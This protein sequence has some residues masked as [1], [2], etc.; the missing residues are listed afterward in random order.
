VSYAALVMG[1]GLAGS[2]AALELARAGRSVVLV[3]K[4]KGPH[5]KVCGEFLSRE[6]LHY[7]RRHN[8][9]LL[10]LGAVPIKAVR[11]IT[12][13]FAEQADLPFAAMSL[14]RRRLD[15]ELLRLAIAA[16]VEVHRGAFVDGLDQEDGTWSAHLRDGRV[17]QASRAILATGKHDLRGRARPQGTHRGLVG[18]KMYYRLTAD[19]A[20]ELGYTVELILFPGG[21]AGLQPVEH[22]A[23]N[24]CLLVHEDRLRQAGSNW[25]G[26]LQHLQ[27]HSPHLAKRLQGATPLLDAPL[28]AASIPYGH[29]QRTA[30]D[31]LWRV[32]DQAA[33]IPSFCGDG[34]AIALH[35]GALAATHLLQGMSADAYQRRL[36][37]QLATRL[38]AATRLSQMLVSWPQAAGIVR[39]FPALLAHIA[40]MTRI[41]DKA[42]TT[43]EPAEARLAIIPSGGRRD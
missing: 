42:L 8:V 10:A 22:G 13:S 29:M 26:L 17:F 35:S 24:L 28:A 1:G 33:V 36:H 25:T 16:G 23:A 41:P 31:D 20:A 4:S 9:D 38:W 32:G 27:E 12:K 34:M 6:S 30:P 19:Q 40:L 15:E 2:M 21:Y 7:L 37:G 11:L 43:A 14:T 18:F 5:D 3:E 39:A